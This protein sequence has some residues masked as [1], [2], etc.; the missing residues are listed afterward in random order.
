MT[1]AGQVDL[2]RLLNTLGPG[3]SETSRL[4]LCQRIRETA[5]SCVRGSVPDL[6]EE[7]RRAVLR[8][9]TE[10]GSEV[11]RNAAQDASIALEACLQNRSAW[12][13]A[14][15]AAPT[16]LLLGDQFGGDEVVEVDAATHKRDLDA[17]SPW[18]AS[19]AAGSGSGGS[20]EKKPRGG[21]VA[22]RLYDALVHMRKEIAA[23]E[24]KMAYLVFSNAVLQLVVKAM[25]RT[26]D[27][28][29]NI[30]GI[31]EEARACGTHA[32]PAASARPCPPPAPG[33]RAPPDAR[34]RY[35]R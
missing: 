16:G 33:S 31:G 25:P 3:T 34:A 7:M 13:D 4:A 8:L 23:D 1:S 21:S 32:S 15:V 27:E 14:P 20:G 2:G 28:L 35:R 11:V 10:D 22:T 30:H 17:R 5:E 18:N 26:K 24:N 12:G 19:G 6:S 9:T 29:Q